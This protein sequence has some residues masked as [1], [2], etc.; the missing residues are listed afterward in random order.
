MKIVS[1]N[2]THNKHSSTSLEKCNVL[3]KKHFLFQIVKYNKFSNDITAELSTG[4][5]IID[6]NF[7]AK[8]QCINF[9]INDFE[10]AYIAIRFYRRQHHISNRNTPTGSV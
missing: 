3:S 9:P 8:S 1:S 2:C 7:I 4:V 5:A 10:I 6:K